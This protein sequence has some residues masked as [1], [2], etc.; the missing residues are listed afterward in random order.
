MSI[1]HTSE[2]LQSA[3]NLVEAPHVD[4]FKAG[5]PSSSELLNRLRDSLITDVV[6]QHERQDNLDA[7]ISM[8]NEIF[9]VALSAL[10]TRFQSLS[11]RLPDRP[12]G[13]W[14]IDFFTNDF[15]HST[16]TAAIDTIY[17]QATLP[18]LSQTEKLV[19]IDTQGEVAVPKAAQVH[20]SYKSTTPDETDWLTD[21]NSIYALDQKNDTAWWRNRASSGAVWIRVQVPANLNANKNANAILLHPYPPLSFDLHSVEYKNPAGVW[22]GADLSYLEGWDGSKVAWFGNIRIF[23]SPSQITELRIKVASANYWGFSKLSLKQ[24]EFSPQATLVVNSVSY[25]PPS[26]S[27]VNLQ[28]KDSDALSY[29][30]STVN[31]FV[32]SAALTQLSAGSSPIISAVELLE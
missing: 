12:S 30:A 11:A 24:I 26:I 23:I 3:K 16:N 17:G 32:I 1:Q 4:V 31:G 22:T 15:I 18:I 25:D 27:R 19:I 5:G 21:D 14:L 6:A 10:S 2:S 28:G 7:K 9:N 13:A 20:Y 8:A 29:L